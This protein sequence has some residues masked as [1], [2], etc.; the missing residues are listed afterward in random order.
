[1]YAEVLFEK[2]GIYGVSSIYK[3]LRSR[4]LLVFKAI[5]DIILFN[6][7]IKKKKH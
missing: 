3:F 7:K 2:D 4:I 1:M 6:A 5:L